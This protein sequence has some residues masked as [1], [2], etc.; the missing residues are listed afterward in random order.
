MALTTRERQARWRA[1]HPEAAAA[2]LAALRERKASKRCRHDPMRRKQAAEGELRI[3]IC[4]DC[5]TLLYDAAELA[6][7]LAAH[8]VRRRVG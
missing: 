1:A 5:G 2:R 7:Y 8:N 4:H 3:W 6:D